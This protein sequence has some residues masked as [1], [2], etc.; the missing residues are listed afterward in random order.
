MYIQKTWLMGSRESTSVFLYRWKTDTKRNDEDEEEE[1]K[2]IRT[3]V[4]DVFLYSSCV[5][6]SRNKME[7]DIYIYC[8][9][10]YLVAI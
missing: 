3:Y 4:P 7:I 6:W 5:F 9:L 2:H 8:S 10:N 1:T